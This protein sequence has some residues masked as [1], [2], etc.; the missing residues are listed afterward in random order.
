MNIDD[1]NIII[2]LQYLLCRYIYHCYIYIYIYL[3]ADY[4]FYVL[5]R[6]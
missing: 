5:S 2:Y 6:V 3:N 4:I 1:Y